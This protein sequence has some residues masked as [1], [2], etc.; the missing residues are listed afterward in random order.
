MRFL[1]GR[2]L[3]VLFSL[4]IWIALATGAMAVSD[5]TESSA[6]EMIRVGLFFG[7]SAKQE[8]QLDTAADSGYQFGF[9]DESRVLHV[10][11]SI[12]TRNV[13]VVP[14]L[15]AS[16][17][18]GEI[19]GFHICLPARFSSFE[20]AAE[21]ARLN[22]GFPA[23]CNGE[24]CAMI[25]SYQ[26]LGD[27]EAALSQ[28]GRD[29]VVY[30]DSGRGVLVCNMEDAAPILLFD[31][32]STHALVL[33]PLDSVVQPITTCAG[34]QYRGDF[35]FNR[36][37]PETLTVSNC[38]S[39]EDY[40]KGVVPNEMSASW[41]MEALKA[42][43]V[44]ARTYALK[45][46]NCFRI[47]GFD[48]ADDTSSQVYRGLRDAD[49]TTDAACDA[50]SGEVLRYEDELCAVYYFAAD[51]GATENAERV[52]NDV[53]IPYL[54]SV[55]DPYEEEL[56]FYCKTWSASASREYLGA[57]FAD[58]GENGIVQSISF[59]NHLYVGDNVR[60]FLALIGAPY[61][62][63]SFTI[64]YDGDSD[65]YVINGKG[66][67]HNLG[68]SQWGAFSMAQNH[69]M[70]YKDILSFYFSGASVS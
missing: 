67:G 62:S 60:E 43:A 32:S 6:S 30:E 25:G 1:I 16:V 29:A 57:L 4:T 61:N 39:I 35:Q 59:G 45:N 66:S 47:F 40:V 19:G 38:V 41:P 44:C 22:G 12:P 36:I 55:K 69:D 31:Y 2:V 28:L 20:E 8:L 26:T 64:T 27:A 51:G 63:R 52:W 53:S 11:G 21:N 49:K 70:N 7:S 5:G 14:D 37:S 9:Y 33:S 54:R 24:F 46:L 10:V 58:Y 17:S 3:L 13:L 42:Q 18:S 15:S 65:R 34:T 56:N 23:F 48:V 50:T 68:M